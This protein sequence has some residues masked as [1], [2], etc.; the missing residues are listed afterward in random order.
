MIVFVFAFLPVIKTLVETWIQSDDNSHGLLIVPI[1]LYIIWQNRA[2]LKC[3]AIEPGVGGRTMVTLAIVLYVFAFKA[4]IATVSSFSLVLAIWAIVWALFGKSVFKNL[5]FPLALL[6]LMIPIPGQIYSM[7]T[8]PLQLM[9]S[10]A[11]AAMVGY[12]DVPVFREGNVIHLPGRTLEVVQACSGLRSLMSLITLCTIF[13][14]MTLSSNFLRGILI[15]S[16]IPAAVLVN[17]FRVVLMII[18]FYYLNLD[19]SEGSLH[20]TFGVVVF[21][22][23]LVLVAMLRGILS[24]WDA[25]REIS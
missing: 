9:V 2:R 4:G 5:V 24:K 25:K 23:A 19:L 11:S 15:V 22:L 13:G 21:V 10:K 14:Y 16:S 7:A 20:T 8:I 3:A 17:I 18:A 1:S 12:L 6:I